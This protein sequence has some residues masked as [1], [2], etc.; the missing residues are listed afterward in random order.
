MAQTAISR[1]IGDEGRAMDRAGSLELLVETIETL[2]AAKSVEEIAAIVRT[3][4]RRL[5]GAD[6]V[7][8]VLRDLDR[9]HYLDEDAVGPLWKGMKFPL[10]A[11]ISGWTMLNNQ[12]AVI[13]D[14][15]QDDRIPHG[16]YRPT[17]VKSLVM[18]PVGKDQP[19]AAIGAYWSVERQPIQEEIDGLRAMARAT[20]TALENVR[21]VASL[22]EAL[23]RRDF[24]I[25]EL[26]H[27]VKN[28]LA[29]VQ[30]IARQTLKTAPT[31]E[32]FVDSFNGRLMALSRAH[33]L[34][35]KEAWKHAALSAV[36]AEAL[37]PFKAIGDRVRVSG[38][39]IVLGPV[40]A[41][42]AHLALHE[43]I[44]N[45]MTHGA[46]SRPDG[47][48]ALV[49]NVE[50]GAGGERRLILV[51]RERGG[52]VIRPPAQKGMGMRLIEQGLPHALDGVCRVDF[53]PSGLR[54]EVIAPLS[55]T[56]QLA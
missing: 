10:T 30:A 19:Q 52:P 1:V 47:D 41:V 14:I 37:S 40:Q 4:A 26:D 38:P 9:C 45:A 31:Q 23:E 21:L 48:V 53:D 25:R 3:N 55:S 8:F 44:T 50:M 11:C 36:A 12:T 5:S 46:L 15:Y 24:L 17:F 32:R 7:T 43:M 27:R 2:A 42:A 35:T 39:P 49:W 22:T 29:S 20:A 56:V 34:L 13:P 16:A 51:W 33:V 28:M 18:T 54:I 6:G